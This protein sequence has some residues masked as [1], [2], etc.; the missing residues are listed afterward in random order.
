M[1]YPSLSSWNN[2][3]HASLYDCVKSVPRRDY[4]TNLFH[5]GVGKRGDSKVVLDA[6]GGFRCGKERRAALH[7]PCEQHLGRGFLDAVGDGDNHRFIQQLRFCTMTQRRKSLEHDTVL[8][9]KLEQ[10][11]FWEIWMGFYVNNGRLYPRG[12]KNPFRLFHTHVRQSDGLTPALVHKTLQSSPRIE[13]RHPFII[14]HF[15][16]LVP[17]VLLVSG[18]KG[19]RG[20][21]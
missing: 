19:E 4:L 1:V 10:L 5:C 2:P 21:D 11:P 7:R 17:R 14:N 9:A 15:A 13:Q 6:G 3:R 18:L 8:V 20:V 16:V 12:F